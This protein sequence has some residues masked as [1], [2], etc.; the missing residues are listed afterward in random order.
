MVASKVVIVLLL[1]SLHTI[2]RAALNTHA[3][4]T[5][6]NDFAEFEDFDGKILIVK[7]LF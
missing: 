4:D 7:T 5:E 2:C 6:D 1:L 3:M